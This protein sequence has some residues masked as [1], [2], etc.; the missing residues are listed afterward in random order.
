MKLVRELKQIV[1]EPPEG[2]TVRHENKAQRKQ[3]QRWSE[4]QTSGWQY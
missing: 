4:T 2:I 1:A 3:G